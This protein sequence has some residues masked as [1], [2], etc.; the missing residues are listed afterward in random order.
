VSDQA[1]TALPVPSHGSPGSYVANARYVF[2]KDRNTIFT[3]LLTICV[4]IIVVTLNSGS[5]SYF[6]FSTMIG[7]GGTLAL[8]AMGQ[9]LVVLTGGF[10]LSAGAVVSLANVVVG[11]TMTDSPW[12]QIFA[13]VL[14]LAVGA[15]AGA[16]NGFF[17]AYLRIQP[18]V[19]TLATLFIVQG[20]ALLVSPTP[21]GY[22]A[23]SFAA[24]SPAR[25]SPASSRPHWW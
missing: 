25:R 12:S 3:A 17:T 5:F 16:F 24:C 21:G 11:T 8:A 15:A 13:G 23:P 10:D 18:I 2:R 22:V 7:T 19:V 6:D 20:V 14:G 4:F 1:R 9:T